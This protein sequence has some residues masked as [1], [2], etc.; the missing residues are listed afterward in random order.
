MLPPFL[1][2]LA[3][4]AAQAPPT[5]PPVLTDVLA[6]GDLVLHSSRSAQSAALRAATGSRWTHV[7]LVFRRDGRWEVLE[8]V[9]PV[10]W[11]PLDAWVRR[12][13]DGDVVALRYDEPFDAQRLQK[14]A[15]AWLDRPYDLLF[16]WSDD[17]IYCSELVWK[18]YH[19]QG[20]DLGTLA[21]MDSFDLSS[22]EVKALIEA[23]TKGSVDLQ[24]PVVA[25]SSF[26]QDE[27]LKV[28]F[29]TP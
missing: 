27:D 23:R 28:V 16:Q 24:E 6:P 11:T 15:E 7:G 26:L 19:E 8:A 4:A 12:G 29:G 21:P 2:F 18:A 13:I 17:T 20:I 5:P 14:A 1:L 9:Q 22:P 10:R 25:P 3:L